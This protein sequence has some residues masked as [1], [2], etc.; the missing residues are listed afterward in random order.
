MQVL[1]L[2]L[3]KQKHIQRRRSETMWREDVDVDKTKDNYDLCLE[4]V[5]LRL[6]RVSGVPEGNERQYD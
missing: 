5:P 4:V 1:Q 2:S 6:Q 3:L